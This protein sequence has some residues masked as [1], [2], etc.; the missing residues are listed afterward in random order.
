MLES[1]RE[2]YKSCLKFSLFTGFVVSLVFTIIT[3]LILFE[4]SDD[5]IFPQN[6]AV[7][8]EFVAIFISIFAICFKCVHEP[9]GGWDFPSFNS[10]E[11]QTINHFFN[12]SLARYLESYNLTKVFFDFDLKYIH[13]E[14]IDKYNSLNYNN[15]KCQKIFPPEE[16]QS[17]CNAVLLL[18]S[19]EY[20]H[21]YVP[22]ETTMKC[23]M[24]DFKESLKDVIG[25]LTKILKLESDSEHEELVRQQKLEQEK[26][27]NW[28][29]GFNG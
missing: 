20:W 7:I 11:I 12:A 10:K 28:V 17:P 21:V 13:M 15:M 19:N 26:K 14:L 3:T 22:E 27:K 23:T 6:K 16:N 4:P 2:H 24:E 8:V 29:Y 18:K 1:R 9:D 25:I 5:T